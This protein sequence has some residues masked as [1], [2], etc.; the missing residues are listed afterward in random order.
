MKAFLSLGAAALIATGCS[1]A[2]PLINTNKP[3]LTPA[4]ETMLGTWEFTT[5][6]KDGI[7]KSAFQLSDAPADTCIS[8]QWFRAKVISAGGLKPSDPAYT[9]SNG[10]LELLLT[11]G[12]CDAYTSFVGTVSGAQFDGTYVSYGLFG[13]T[14]HGKVVGFR[15]P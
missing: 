13:G 1:T 6:D 4:P 7:R 9:Y 8:G 15:R 12:L 5:T 14:E 3:S 2:P 10:R 11:N